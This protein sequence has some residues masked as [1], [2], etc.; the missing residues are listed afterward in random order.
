MKPYYIII[1]LALA[2]G[3]YYEEPR[4]DCSAA[5]VCPGAT[6]IWEPA[7]WA[8]VDTTNDPLAVYNECLCNGS[9]AVWYWYK[10]HNDQPFCDAQLAQWRTVATAAGCATGRQ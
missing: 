5:Y 2:C 9:R 8:P 10:V 7:T 6:A 1:A 4:A 3:G